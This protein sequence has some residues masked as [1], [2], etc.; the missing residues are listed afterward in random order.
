M[1]TGDSIKFDQVQV[2]TPMGHHLVKDLSFEIKRGQNLL[3]TG[4]NG[5]GKS[6]IF[7]CLGGLWNVPEGTITK[8]G[9]SPGESGGSKT[10]AGL[11]DLI[12]YLPQK[13]YN[14]LGS[15]RDQLC[16][17]KTAADEQLT[18]E[19]MQAFLDQ[20]DLGYLMQYDNGGAAGKGE[21]REVINW[22]EKLS[23]GEQQRLAI[24]RLF[25]HKPQFAILDECT[26]SVST[27][28][29]AML[30]RKCVQ[31]NITCITSK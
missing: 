29:E 21:E 5:A 19:H 13:P 28:M 6:S 25:F 22:Q 23:L 9:L 18:T 26:S 27:E 10:A 2:F 31:M 14:V 1:V 17:P 4:H 11:H 3:L 15:L 12:F 30:Y 20:V 16:Y 24:A 7:R 8:P